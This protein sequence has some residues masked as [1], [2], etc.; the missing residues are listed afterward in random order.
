MLVSNESKLAFVHVQKTGGRSVNKVLWENF[1]DLSKLG[2]RHIPFAQAVKRQPELE[3]YFV[4]G[5]VRNPWDRLVSW[6]SMID[7][8]QDTPRHARHL[9]EN[10]FWQAVRADFADFDDFVRRGVGASDFRPRQYL[11]LRM[12]QSQ[13][14]TDRDGN[15]RGD[16]VG[17]T[18]RLDEDLATV[19]ARFDIHLDTVPRINRSSHSHYADYYSPA[20][21]DIVARVFAEDLERFGYRY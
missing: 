12:S 15:F 21:R 1:P 9:P 18:E 2:R 11:R 16:F 3:A 10:K 4:F 17:R 14:F 20:S 7:A 19:M 6:Y 5:F 13:Y 8:A